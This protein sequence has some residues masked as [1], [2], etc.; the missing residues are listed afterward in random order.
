MVQILFR[1]R[2]N[3]RLGLGLALALKPILLLKITKIGKEDL[4]NG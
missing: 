4:N 2:G 3:L 1:T